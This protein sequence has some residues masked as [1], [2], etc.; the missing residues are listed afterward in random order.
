MPQ[1]LAVAGLEFVKSRSKGAASAVAVSHDSSSADD[2][3]ART[4]SRSRLRQTSRKPRERAGDVNSQSNKSLVTRSKA[5]GKSPAAVAGVSKS[6]KT[7]TELRRENARLRGKLVATQAEMTSA[8][9]LAQNASLKAEN[10][11]L[12]ELISAAHSENKLVATG[13]TMIDLL[14]VLR[15]H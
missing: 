8:V 12:R 10:A 2:G 13:D 11:H 7:L 1:D 4:A 6:H 9:A 14:K 15:H 3:G 5:K